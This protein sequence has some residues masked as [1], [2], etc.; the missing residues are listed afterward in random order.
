MAECDIELLNNIHPGW[1][2]II[3]DK[4][5]PALKKMQSGIKPGG[6]RGDLARADALLATFDSWLR[7]NWDQIA[8]KVGE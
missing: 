6:D 5:I 3:R 8:Q 2:G 7:A 4:F 1:G